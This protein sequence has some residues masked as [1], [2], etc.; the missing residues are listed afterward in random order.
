MPLR[1]ARPVAV[2][3]IAGALLAPG[4]AQ[5][6]GGSPIDD[7]RAQAARIQRQ[8][9]ANGSRIAALGEQYNGALLAFD[10]ATAAIAEARRRFDAAQA[11]VAAKR[12]LLQRRAV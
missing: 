10:Q 7:K 2:L 9:E 1:F 12:K 4:A 3:V 6:A 8:V 5:S 11:Q